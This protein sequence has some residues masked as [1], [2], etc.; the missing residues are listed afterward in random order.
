MTRLV[1]FL[2]AVLA[3]AMGGKNWAASLVGDRCHWESR[4]NGT[5]VLVCCNPDTGCRE[6]TV[7]R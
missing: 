4:A 7:R 1:I 2:F 5:M 3:V 6:T